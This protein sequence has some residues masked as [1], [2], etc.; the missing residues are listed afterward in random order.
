[1]TDLSEILKNSTYPV[2]IGDFPDSCYQEL[3]RF[4]FIKWDAS[5]RWSFGPNSACGRIEKRVTGKT[6]STLVTCF[7]DIFSRLD[8]RM[9]EMI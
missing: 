5:Y 6:H 9:S 4:L 8:V 2:A 1:M 3:E 7:F